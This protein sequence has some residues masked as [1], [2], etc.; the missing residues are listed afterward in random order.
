MIPARSSIAFPKSSVSEIDLGR[1]LKKAITELCESL[2][3]QFGQIIVFN[4]GRVYRIRTL[5]TA[6]D[7]A[8][9]RPGI[10]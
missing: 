4:N 10:G 3:I 7:T 2:H 8:H 9:G 6:A 1:I 5:R